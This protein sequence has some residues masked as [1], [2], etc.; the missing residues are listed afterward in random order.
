[1]LEDLAED[2][3]A[4]PWAAGMHGVIAA[5]LRV[6]AEVAAVL[7][8]TRRPPGLGR[9]QREAVH[10]LAEEGGA[11]LARARTFTDDAATVDQLRRLD[12]LTHDFVSTVSHELRTPMTVLTGLGRTLDRRWEELS[13]ER[14]TDLLRRIDANAQRLAAMVSSLIDT[15]AHDQGRLVA[16][17]EVV[18]PAELVA[19]V[20]GRLDTLLSGHVVEVDVTD[21]EAAVAD[22]GLIAHVLE[23]LLGNAARHTPV[24]TQVQVTVRRVDGEVEVAVADDGPGI[25]EADLPHVL[26]RFFRGGTHE[27]RTAGGLGLGLALARQIVA[28]HGGELVVASR[29]GEGTRFS[30]RLPTA[31]GRGAGPE[32]RT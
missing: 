26:E 6:G 1:V 27:T 19:D 32:G 31:D 8:A 17:P 20:L 29:P 16:H 28:A 3:G 11:A 10:L 22:P 14:R 7:V 15:S 2:P 5:P 24:G 9:T 13:D 23:N 18:A 4:L 21:G 25:P 12:E 30:F